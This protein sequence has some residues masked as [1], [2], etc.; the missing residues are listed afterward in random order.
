MVSIANFS[1]RVVLSCFLSTAFLSANALAQTNAELIQKE[2]NVAITQWQA[3]RFG[4]FIHFG[5]YADLAGVWQGKQIEKLGEQ[6]QRHADIS[7]EDYQ[8]V[9]KRFNPKNFD[10]D[11]IVKLAKQAGM[12][13]IVLTT[14]H[15]DGFALFD[16]KHT[17]FDIVD[18][19]P[20][21]KDLLKELSDATK[22]H[23]L[24]L[25]LYYSTPDWHFNGPSPERNPQ[26]G[27][28][29]VFG[30]VSKANEDYQV[31]QLEEL[32]TNYGDIVEV[33][34]DMGEP[35]LAQSKRFRDVVKKYQPNALING[36]V[37]NN[38]GDFLTMPDNHVPDSPITDYPWETP[39][40]FY[41]TWGYKSWVKG[42]PLKQQIG[43]QIRK[44]SDIASMGGNF[45]LNIGPKGDGSILAYEEDVLKGVGQWVNKNAEAI[46]ETGLNPFLKMDWGQVSTRKGALYLHVH[47]WPKDNKLVIPGLV[48]NVKKVTPLTNRQNNLPV[49]QS[50][51]NTVIDLSSVEQDAYLTIVKLV[52]SGELTVI[53]RHSKA[54]AQGNIVLAGVQATKHGKFGK[55]SYRSMLKD[56]SRSWYVDVPKAGK[57]QV[58]ITYKM[59]YQDKDF[60]L[61][62]NANELAFNLKGKGDKVE[63]VQAF[64]GNEKTDNKK[65]NT[66]QF[67]QTT[68]GELTFS[69]SGIQ[70]VMLKQG[71]PFELKTLMKDFKAQDMRYRSMNIEI[72]TIELISL[73]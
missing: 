42:L 2:N 23:G 30:K 38:Q 27:K 51:G 35:T 62:N 22:R 66:G 26:D 12:R 17:D 5:A 41:H 6:I 28:I 21:K 4:L 29:S 31:A 49:T 3:M 34:F 59:R 32:M 57:Y 9:V 52:Y 7:Q 40:T 60:I 72:E 1:K 55:E 47:Q 10:A 63:V 18:Y 61:V 14:K 25:G 43:V 39:G 11:A 15:H 13:Y 20:Y 71:Q 24:K 16:S 46:F 56:F 45:L 33:F 58:K 54:N 70:Q 64:D 68:I 19:T 50:N 8:E 73:N 36:R 48:N 53:P 69:K 65:N 67:L 44:L 37:M